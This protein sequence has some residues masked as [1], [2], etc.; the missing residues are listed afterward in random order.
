MVLLG[1]FWTI[2]SVLRWTDLGAALGFLGWL[3]LL[4]SG[5]LIT[6]LFAIWWLTASRVRWA[7]RLPVFATA[8]AA[9]VAAGFLVDKTI[10][11][12]LLVPGIPLVLTI[13]LFTLV[14]LRDWS[15]EQRRAV[16]AG[17]L[18]LSWTTF[19]LIRTEGMWGDGQ[20]TLFWRWSLTPEQVYLAEG[21]QTGGSVAAQKLKLQAG[22]WPEFRGPKRDSNLHNVRIATN[23]KQSPPELVWKRRVG[24][25]WSSIIVVGDRLFTQE[26][27][28]KSEAIVCLDSATGKTL[29]SHRDEARHE[30]V[31]GGIGPRATPTFADGRIFALG[32]TGILNCLDAATGEHI[33]HRDIAADS[34]AKV[35]MWGFSSS[36]LVVDNR[37]VVFAGGDGDKTL[38]A[39]HLDSGNPTWSAAAGKVSYSSPQLMTTGK[40]KHL[41]FV[42]DRG[43]F[44]FDPSSGAELY[45]YSTEA[46]SPGVPRATQPQAPGGGE[47]LFDAGPDVGTVSLEVAQQDGSWKA[48]KRWLA[49]QLKPNFNDF[50]VHDG[51]IYGFDARMLTCIDLQTGKRRWKEGRYGSGQVLLLGD[52]PLL[53]VVTEEG[54][55]VLIAANAEEH[56][57]LGRFQALKGKTWGHPVIARGR[58]Y[59]RNAEWMA[60]YKLQPLSTE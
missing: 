27:F 36:P 53:M 25:A 37:V 33:W 28:G 6:L 43:L 4:G 52:Q 14:L 48:S 60:C 59:I 49:R 35:P 12:T 51:A 39:Y 16:L 56:K 23:W 32:A 31:Q 24:P 55:L 21:E 5:A 13:W 2:Y 38:L 44:A 15:S 30:D 29:W 18:F 22:D 20:F 57:E 26:Q 11:P 58:L 3:I 17:V 34:G 9:G 10:V 1:I 54:E 50:V 41:L 19:T 42:S 40:E 46:G 8:L 7:E 47:L 45:S